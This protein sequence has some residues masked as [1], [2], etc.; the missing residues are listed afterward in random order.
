MFG[1]ECFKVWPFAKGTRMGCGAE[2]RFSRA[3]NQA[4]VHRFNE[5]DLSEKGVGGGAGIPHLTHRVLSARNYGCQEG[6]F[7]SGQWINPGHIG[8]T[9]SQDKVT[10]RVEAVEGHQGLGV[11]GEGWRHTQRI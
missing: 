2:K 9:S 1:G 10:R 4:V 7:P 11:R 6:G 5:G 8:T 3:G